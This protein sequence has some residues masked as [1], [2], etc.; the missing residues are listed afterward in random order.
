MAN[1]HWGL[2]EKMASGPDYIQ[3]CLSRAEELRALAQSMTNAEARKLL[4]RVA[5]DYERLAK[6]LRKESDGAH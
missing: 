2:D 1:R 4:L 6:S 5:D 3:E